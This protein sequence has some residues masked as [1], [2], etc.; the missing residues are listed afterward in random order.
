MGKKKRTRTRNKLGEKG[1]T[2]EFTD[3]WMDE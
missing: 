2:Q 1:K 3:N